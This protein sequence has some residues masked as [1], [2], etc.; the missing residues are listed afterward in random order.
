MVLVGRDFLYPP[1]LRVDLER[2]RTGVTTAHVS[3]Y[4]VDDV[5]GH[6]LARSS[7]ADTCPVV[8]V[9][10]DPPRGTFPFRL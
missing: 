6:V 2:R 3:I 9:V 5:L 10:Q 7:H 4:L 8:G 1:R